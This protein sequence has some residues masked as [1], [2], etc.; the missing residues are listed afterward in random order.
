M[1]C[2]IH[3]MIEARRDFTGLGPR[4]C[5][6][7]HF[8]PN[9]YYTFREEYAKVNGF[10]VD[11]SERPWEHESIY[12]GRNYSLFSILSGVRNYD[13]MPSLEYDLRGF[14]DDADV[15][16]KEEYDRWGADAHTPGYCTLKELKDGISKLG[17]VKCSGY[18]KK[19]VQEKYLKDGTLPESWMRQV[20]GNNADQYVYMEWE[21]NTMVTDVCSALIEAIEQR[22][23]EAFW[24]FRPEYDDF[25]RDDDIRIVFWYDN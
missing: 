4:W 2:D 19:E 25:S 14:P 3:V 1:G 12:N 17:V 15:L 13:N 10:E 9:P 21:D 16:T 5:N 22:K 18:V 23:R 7:D 6:V 20:F 11:E 8:T 24:I